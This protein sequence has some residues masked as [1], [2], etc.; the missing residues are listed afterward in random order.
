MALFGSALGLLVELVIV[1]SIEDVLLDCGHHVVLQFLLQ[2]L[3][4][5]SLLFLQFL[6][7]L[8]FFLDLLDVLLIFPL[9]VLIG[10]GQLV[11]CDLDERLE[12]FSRM[13]TN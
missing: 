7:F 8:S 5:E 13:T 3:L 9:E 2:L 12:L 6:F 11:L 1:N 4:L 10:L